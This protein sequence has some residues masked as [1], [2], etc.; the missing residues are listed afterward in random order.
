METSITINLK[1]QTCDVVVRGLHLGHIN[2]LSTV[3]QAVAENLISSLIAVGMD[4]GK[5]REG[6]NLLLQGTLGIQDIL[7]AVP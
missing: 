3:Q 4:S 5:A 1:D 6:V 2:K 7:K